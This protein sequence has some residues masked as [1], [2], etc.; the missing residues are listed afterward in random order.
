MRRAIERRRHADGVR[1]RVRAL[2][3]RDDAL[4]GGEQPQRLERLVVGDG[5][6]AR[7]PAVA[8]P[9]VLGADAGIVEPG[10][11]RV[12]VADLPGLVLQDVRLVPCS[13]PTCP[14]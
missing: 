5:D 2:E 11:D 8:Q 1:D 10:G 3:R 13:T 9:G 4:G 12:R 6:V 14:P 7:P